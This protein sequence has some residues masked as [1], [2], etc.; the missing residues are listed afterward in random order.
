MLNKEKL[1]LAT[2]FLSVS[3][4]CFISLD[5]DFGWHLASGQYFLNNGLPNYDIF[6]YTAS[7]FPWVN[8]EWLND[9]IWA[10]L[11]NCGGFLLLSLFIGIIWTLAA[12]IFLRQARPLV[13]G[14]AF[15]GLI[16]YLGVRASSW[17]VLAVSI[18]VWLMS[19]KSYRKYLPLLFIIWANLHGS[20]VIGLAYVAYETIRSRQLSLF[21][22][23][24]L[25]ILA[26]F[27]NPYG[28]E[29]YRE[30]FSTIFDSSLRWTINEWRPL[31]IEYAMM[32][33][34]VLWASMF[35]ITD[36]KKWRSYLGLDLILFFAGL[37]SMRNFMI[38]ILF[39][40]SY[41]NRRLV[42]ILEPIPKDLDKN[43]KRFVLGSKIVICSVVCVFAYAQISNS[44][45][46]PES[47]YPVEAVNYF[48]KHPC[49]GNIFN[50]Y[51]YGGYMI[52]HLPG[53]KVYID[54]RMP[55]W[56]HNGTKYLNNYFDVSK[57]ETFRKAEFKKYNITCVIISN[58]GI[59]G[60][61][62]DNL[63]KE[64]WKAFIKTDD[65]TLYL[66]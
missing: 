18:L 3:I 65:Y 10:F 21:K 6:T 8:H 25:C 27:I 16:P 32:P 17:T 53:Q 48:K 34:I 59:E 63:K 12:F 29:L 46:L 15:V 39:S 64:G 7:D 37:S 57:D 24:L 47:Y 40:I 66:K 52:W 38:F 4:I 23:L 1:F 60:T 35:V 45:P 13:V 26:T 33:Y 61:L 5:P 28:I 22:L 55:S 50:N 62:G 42:K 51:S 19:S 36:L 14:M 56:Q 43:R 11:Y 41:T 54:G 49:K 30:I 9:I 31:D 2:V 20:F 44:P 58:Y